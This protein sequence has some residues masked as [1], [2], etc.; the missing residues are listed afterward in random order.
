MSIRRAI[1]DWAISRPHVHKLFLRFLAVGLLNTLFGYGCFAFLLFSG[2][3][4]SAALFMA[5]VAGVLFNFKTTGAW[6][7]NSR[8]GHLIFRFIASYAMVY[9][10]NVAGIKL[11]L[12][13]GLNPYLG[14]AIL[15]LPI[16]ILSFTLQRKYVFH[17][18]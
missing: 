11:L 1:R 13:L 18:A 6:V 3:H 12:Q 9:G 5:T 15:L 2:M 7:F 16:A 8:S 10:I 17:H 14:G 4:Y